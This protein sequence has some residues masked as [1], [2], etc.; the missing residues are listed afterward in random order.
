MRHRRSRIASVLANAVAAVI[1]IVLLLAIQPIAQAQTTVYAATESGECGTLNLTNAEF[2]PIGSLGIT[3]AALAGLGA[4]LYTS[5]YDG[6][7][8]YQ[9]EIPSCTLSPLLGNA[10]FDYRDFGGTTAGLY[11]TDDGLNLYS[12]N[13]ATGTSTLIGSMNISCN[14]TALSADGPMLYFACNNASPVLYSVNTTTAALTELA[15][16][17]T[18]NIIALVFVAGELYASTLGGELYEINPSNGMIIRNIGSSGQNIDATA[19]PASTFSVL[20][21]FSSGANGSNPFAGLVFN[22]AGTTLYG[23]TGAGGTGDCS[24]SGLTGC[25]TFFSLKMTNGNWTFD[26][27]Y[28]FQGGSND[29]EFPA[30]PVTVGSNGTVYGATLGGGDGSCS[31]DGDSACGF[32]Y[33]LGPSP[34]PPRTPLQHWTK[35]LPDPYH[36]TGESDGGVPFTTVIFDSSGNIYGTT[37]YGGSVNTSCPNGCG[38]VFKLTPTG[39]GNYTESVIY[40]FQGVGASDGALPLDGLIFDTA[41]NLYGTTAAGGSSSAC[42]G[43]GCGIVF[44]LSPSGSGWTE[45]ILYIFQG[46]SDG[47]NPNSGVIIDSAQYLYGNTWTG[48]SGG[49]G[50][51]WRLPSAGGTLELLYSVPVAGY[52]VGRVTMDSNGNLYNV[53]Q[54]GGVYNDGQVFELTPSNG[55]WIYT[56]LYDFTG[57]TDG[58]NPIGGAVLDSSGNIYG[59]ALFGGANS[60]CGSNGTTGCGDVWKITPTN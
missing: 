42:S 26:P 50:T 33:N 35:R 44:K 27:L 13:A 20:H 47:A 19:L 10:S 51:V 23:S 43:S 21:N 46:S 37:A 45:T 38:T 31:F 9:V 6:T 28:S 12:I 11:G 48:G 55:T 17:N 49:G 8:L 15:S 3:P 53:L 40:P 5:V 29:G 32:V 41:G 4:S 18:N 2:T 59:T 24:Y 30:R 58:S 22:S 36:F 56:D 14:G 1:A 52:A 16:E 57:G 7:G 60:N 39:G 34:T 25:G 54:N